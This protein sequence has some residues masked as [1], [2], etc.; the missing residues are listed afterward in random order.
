ME[1]IMAEQKKKLTK[2]QREQL[3][4]RRTQ[5]W[6]MS[7]IEQLAKKPMTDVEVYDATR[8]DRPDISKSKKVHNVASQ[9]TYLKDDGYVVIRHEDKLVAIADPEDN[10][11]PGAEKYL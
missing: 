2:E 8:P 11:Y 9:L 5:P 4:A 7:I 3:T 6:R 10:L 1:V